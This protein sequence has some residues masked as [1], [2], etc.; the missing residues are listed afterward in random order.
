MEVKDITNEEFDE[1]MDD[2]LFE[3]QEKK[4]LVNRLSSDILAE[5]REELNNEVL[6]R[7]EER[8]EKAA[9]EAKLKNFYVLTTV[10]HCRIVRAED[11]DQARD[12]Y[13]EGEGEDCG[14][15][16]TDISVREVKW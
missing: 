9:S 15:E 3:L 14:P 16:T 2:L 10:V 8:R 11:E 12:F 5:L 4:L 13:E 7:V 1:A 6:E